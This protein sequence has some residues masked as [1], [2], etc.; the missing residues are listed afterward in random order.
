MERI[1]IFCG[2]QRINSNLHLSQDTSP[3]DKVHLFFN[4]E[5]YELVQREINFY[6]EQQI[7]KR[8]MSPGTEIC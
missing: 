8:R 1:M 4:N 5:I 7:N 3:I 2:L 6:A